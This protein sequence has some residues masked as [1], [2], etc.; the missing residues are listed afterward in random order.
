MYQTIDEK[1][2]VA[3]VFEVSGFVPKKFE[4]RSKIYPIQEITLKN[5]V[6]DGGVRKRFY[7]VMSRGNVYR[8]VFNRDSEEW[9]LAEMWFEG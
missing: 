4:W 6:K 2:R 3:G 1:I 8:I 5:D 9:Q 7:S